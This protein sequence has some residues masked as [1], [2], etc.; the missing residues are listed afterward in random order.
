[1]CTNM[2]IYFYD[3]VYQGLGGGASNGIIRIP[4]DLEDSQPT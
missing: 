4:S 2:Y 1:M 3:I